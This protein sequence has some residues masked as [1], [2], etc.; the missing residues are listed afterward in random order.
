MEEVAEQMAAVEGT[1]ATVA[2]EC[3]VAERVVKLLRKAAGTTKEEPTSPF[4][5]TYQTN[6]SSLNSS[7]KSW[8]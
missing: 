4:F 8:V 7:P 3:L 6:S 2:V 5:S 1:T